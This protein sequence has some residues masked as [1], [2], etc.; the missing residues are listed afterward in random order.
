MGRYFQWIILTALTGS[1]V[2]SILIL[3]V[4]WFAVDRFT[5]GLFPDPVRF[6]MRWRRTWHLE[7]T[8]AAN[9]HDRRSRFELAELYIRQRRYQRAENVLKPN[10]VAGDDDV[11]TLYS[12]GVA[13]CGAGHP[14]QGEVFLQEATERDEGFRL[15]AIDLERGRWRLKRGDAKG[16]HQAL[17]RFVGVRRGTIE[18]RVLL[19]RAMLGEG[20]EPQA[21][22]MREEAWKE[23]VSAPRF[24][25][26]VERFWAWRAK[27]SRPLAYLAILMVA[28][29]VFGRYVAP[30]LLQMTEGMR[31]SSAT[32]YGRYRPPSRPPAPDEGAP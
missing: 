5:F 23:Y 25:R 26:R 6:V 24:Q 18:G 22:L 3:L 20:N 9:P 12:M 14:D 15:G 13:C 32:P 8:L 10:L 11:P 27:P 21:A 7:R 19:A 28:G 30:T 1:P 4:F 31:G 17:E 29:A 2:L 16:A